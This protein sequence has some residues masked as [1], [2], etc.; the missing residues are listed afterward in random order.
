MMAGEI[1]SY[2]PKQIAKM[3]SLFAGSQAV[4]NYEV[5]VGASV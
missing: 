2:Y 3:G 4:E 1:S 5:S